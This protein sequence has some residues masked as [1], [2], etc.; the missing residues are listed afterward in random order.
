M[1]VP[2]I[3]HLPGRGNGQPICE[4]FGRGLTPEEAYAVN[5]L[6]A[7]VRATK[8]PEGHSFVKSWQEV[9]EVTCE[10]CRRRYT[11]V[12]ASP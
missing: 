4:A 8:Y 12:C 1:D 10:E 5:I 9:D 7:L 11:E 6:G 3:V 2:G